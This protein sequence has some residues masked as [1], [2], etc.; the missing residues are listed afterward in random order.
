MGKGGG[1][2]I[3]NK[4]QNDNDLERYVYLKTKKYDLFTLDDLED[5]ELS[6][7]ESKLNEKLEK[8]EKWDRIF[9][10]LKKKNIH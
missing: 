4:E 8:A 5:K 6:D 10:L 3:S 2:I 7:V 9:K 1:E